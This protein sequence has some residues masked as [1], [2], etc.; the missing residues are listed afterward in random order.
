[1]DQTRKLELNK[2]N[3]KE[4]E[5]ATS[6]KDTIQIFKKGKEDRTK[7]YWKLAIWNKRAI[8]GRKRTN[9]ASNIQK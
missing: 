3:E 6:I 2:K 9:I 7:K 4:K 5:L 8:N 1:M